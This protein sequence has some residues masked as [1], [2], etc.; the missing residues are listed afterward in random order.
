MKA[1]GKLIPE[2]AVAAFLIDRTEQYDQGSGIYAAICERVD[3]VMDGKLSDDY[4]AGELD[5]LR[6]RVESSS[7]WRLRSRK[8]P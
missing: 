8:Q 4:A 6:G 5:D 1:S 3:E 2:W 7:R